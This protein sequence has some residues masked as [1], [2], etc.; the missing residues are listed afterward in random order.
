MKRYE[1][2]FQSKFEDGKWLDYVRHTVPHPD[3][4]MADIRLIARHTGRPCRAWVEDWS[5]EHPH[6]PNVYY[7]DWDKSQL[8][9]AAQQT[10]V[11][12]PVVY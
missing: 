9:P 4:A 12:K 5:D 2:I 3:D 1:A 10:G 6:E 8:S 7:G 11:F